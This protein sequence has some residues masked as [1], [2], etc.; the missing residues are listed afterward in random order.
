MRDIIVGVF[1]W[2]HLGV[3]LEDL[4]DLAAAVSFVSCW[5][6]PCAAPAIQPLPDALLQLSARC[7]A[8]SFPHNIPSISYLSWPI[9]SPDPSLFAHPDS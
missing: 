4:D 7:S 6:R 5:T 3:L 1:A 9:D 8:S 2:F